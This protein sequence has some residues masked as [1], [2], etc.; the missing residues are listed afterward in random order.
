MEVMQLKSHFKLSYSPLLSDVFLFF[1]KLRFRK[2]LN[3]TLTR[4]H[5]LFL[6]ILRLHYLLPFGLGLQSQF[7]CMA[8]LRF[9]GLP[10]DLHRLEYP[11]CQ[12]PDLD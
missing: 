8:I 10:Q 4:T 7:C 11:L 2:V 12:P 3:A 5:P 6:K 9:L 1:A